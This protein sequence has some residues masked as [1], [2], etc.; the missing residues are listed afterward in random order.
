MIDLMK[1]LFG[2]VFVASLV[3]YDPVSILLLIAIF[4]IGLVAEIRHD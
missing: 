4:I 3:V 1:V 2:G